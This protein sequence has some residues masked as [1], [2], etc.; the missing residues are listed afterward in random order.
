MR[1]VTFRH[2][3][4]TDGVGAI[5]GADVLDLREAL[6]PSRKQE[7]GWAPVSMLDLLFQGSE[8]LTQVAQAIANLQGGPRSHP[9]FNPLES[10]RLLAPVPRPPKL[11]YVGR[12]YRDHIAEGG[13]QPTE[14]PSVFAKFPSNVIG[15]LDPIP[16]PARSSKVDFEAELAVV[17]GSPTRD[18]TVERALECVAGFTIANDVSARDVQIEQDQLTLGKNFR[19][20]APLGPW[21]VTRDEL[22]DPTDLRIRLWLNDQLMQDASTADMVF[23]VAEIVSFLSSCF[24]LEPGDIISTG[25]PA[26]VGFRRQPP[27]H[28]RPGDWIRVSI[29]GIGTLENSV[30]EP[31]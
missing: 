6:R 27:V 2:Q 11:V 17:I 30:V 15:H 25:T 26:G 10:V 23:G 16:I 24:D 19:D 8:A 21:I 1:L 9:L 7:H 14:F 3:D 4:G 18:V 20:F 31:D 5:V 22:T 29:D 12:N 28:L 13:G